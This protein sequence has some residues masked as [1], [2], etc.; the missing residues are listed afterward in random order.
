MDGERIPERPS[1]QRGS[2]T[3][4]TSKQK[5]LLTDLVTDYASNFPQQIAETRMEQY[6]KTQANLFF[7]WSG[8]IEP[9]EAH[10]YRIQTPAFLIEY[11][12]TQNNANHIHT[13]WRDFDGDFGLDLLAQHY[14]ASH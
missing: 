11:D 12:D 13:V 9:G 3:K 5:E 2:P 14:Q 4:M 7:A 10:Y 1:S 6:R 8:G